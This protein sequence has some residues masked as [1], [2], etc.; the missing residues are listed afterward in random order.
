MTTGSYG[1]YR[2]LIISTGE[3]DYKSWNG[4]DGKYE[5]VGGKRLKWNP[6]EMRTSR[7]YRPSIR[8][9]FLRKDSPGE[10]PYIDYVNLSIGGPEP[11]FLPFPQD[12]TYSNNDKLAIMSKLIE[13]VKSHDF[14]LAVNAAQGRQLVDMVA[15]N[16]RK[17]TRSLVALKRGD[18]A[19]AARQLGVSTKKKSA[20]KTT[21][22]SGRWLELQYGWLPSLS[23]TFEAAKAFEAIS[24]GP[25]TMRVSS[26]KKRSRTTT[27]SN[28]IVLWGW[29][30]HSS[31]RISVELAEEMEAERQL[32]LTDPLS[33]VWE[34]TPYSFVLD[35]FL[36]IGEYLS[37]LAQIPYL[38]GRFLITER[39]WRSGPIL[40]WADP[41]EPFV[42]APIS[43][44]IDVSYFKDVKRTPEDSL[45]P[46]L[47]NFVDGLTGSPKR[48]F[49]A[50]A[51]A[52]Q[53]VSP[54][55]K[56]FTSRGGSL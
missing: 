53:L 12:L 42:V 27:E 7:R 38:K 33:V 14:N 45:S 56:G 49:N 37:V 34:L 43:L 46:P 24:N 55:S 47:P 44:P 35:W 28:G 11:D 31:Y 19:T 52:H 36:P 30:S 9:Y 39:R 8:A 54:S 51:L 10:T 50:I 23:D 1:S 4:S 32:G 40:E 16:L 22:I 17:M 3:Y 48:I 20:L 15:S 29:D 13:R 18:F 25:R 6:Y 26:A 2:S 41:H 21:D 5:I